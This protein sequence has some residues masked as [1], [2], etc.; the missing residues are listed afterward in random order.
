MSDIPDLAFESKAG[1]RRFI[2][3]P[4]LPGYVIEALKAKGGML[5]Q[6]VHDELSA[7]RTVVWNNSQY[8]VA[9]TDMVD[10]ED[11]KSLK[12]SPSRTIP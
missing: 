10:H 3:R 6:L 2:R 8:R 1:R 11:G 9:A 5:T 7:V 4:L 12:L